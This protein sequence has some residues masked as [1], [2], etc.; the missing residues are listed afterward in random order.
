MSLILKICF[1]AQSLIMAFCSVNHTKSHDLSASFSSQCKIGIGVCFLLSVFSDVTE[2]IST[3][4][5]ILHQMEVVASQNESKSKR[6]LFSHIMFLYSFIGEVLTVTC[7]FI[8]WKT[9]VSK[10]PAGSLIQSR[11]SPCCPSG[12]FD[13]FCRFNLVCFSLPATVQRA[14][15][16]FRELPLGV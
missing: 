7:S 9:E 1:L 8:L 4:D 15:L 3:K 10:N 5:R 13:T 2:T 11:S 14:S 16:L 12:D 6:T